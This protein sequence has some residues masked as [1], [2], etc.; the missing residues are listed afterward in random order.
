[1]L[2]TFTTGLFYIFLTH[3]SAGTNICYNP[4]GTETTST[5]FTPCFP[6]ANVTHCCDNGQTCLSNGLCLGKVREGIFL[7]TAQLL[8]LNQGEM[9]MNTGLCTDS[10]WQADSCF[11]Y[12]PKPRR[13]H[14]LSTVYRCSNNKWCCSGGTNTT[15]CCQDGGVEKFKITGSALVQNGSAFVDGYSIA[16]I[17]SILTGGE[18]STLTASSTA[19]QTI[20]CTTTISGSPVTLTATAAGNASATPI[21]NSI[22]SDA[23]LKTGLGAGLG[24]GIPLLVV[25]G[26][27][28]F[29]LLREK[30]RHRAPRETV[31]EGDSSGHPLVPGSRSTIPTQFH[32]TPA[33]SSLLSPV[34]TWNRTNEV[35]ELNLFARNIGS[36]SREKPSGCAE[37]EGS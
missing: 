2:F 9:A 7:L 1:M 3:V 36:N 23:A 31:P 24:V 35:D 11:S 26:V 10:T 17:G 18:L 22:K 19:M 37:L 25:I 14:T 4:D 30:R 8:K 28:S 21:S 5:S 27:L 29:L 32:A 34:S 12:C 20:T 13:L 15:S 6:S 33:E 16:P